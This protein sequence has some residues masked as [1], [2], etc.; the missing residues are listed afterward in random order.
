MKDYSIKLDFFQVVYV[1]LQASDEEAALAKVRELI[2]SGIID[3]GA[4]IR[5]G[6]LGEVRANIEIC[7]FR[8]ASPEEV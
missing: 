8:V 2:A 1:C 3:A 6:E 4:Q 5:S 7:D